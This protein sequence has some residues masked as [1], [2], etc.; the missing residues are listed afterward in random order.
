LDWLMLRRKSRRTAAALPPVSRTNKARAVDR[1][2][3]II[4]CGAV[5]QRQPTVHVCFC[6][7]TPD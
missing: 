2:Q 6:A 5:L 3:K 4:D 7:Y 1:E